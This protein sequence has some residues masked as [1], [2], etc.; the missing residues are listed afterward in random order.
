[1]KTRLR[2][3]EE[4]GM[5]RWSWWQQPASRIRLS[6]PIEKH[7]QEP[8]SPHCVKLA[9]ALNVSTED[10]FT[11][12]LHTPMGKTTKKSPLQS[13]PH[14]EDGQEGSEWCA[15][16]FFV[17]EINTQS[18]GDIHFSHQLLLLG[19]IFPMLDPCL[20]MADRE[21]CSRFVS[22]ASVCVFGCSGT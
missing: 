5:T 9:R 15:R 22:L 3:A 20:L 18:K 4:E 8:V 21:R 6:L 13:L 17:A 19:L 11:D 10:L 14:R 7:E 16:F 1:M 12:N 2:Y